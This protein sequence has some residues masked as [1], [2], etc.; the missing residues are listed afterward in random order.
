MKPKK[1]VEIQKCQVSGKVSDKL[2]KQI[3]CKT[4]LSLMCDVTQRQWQIADDQIY[5]WDDQC[6]SQCCVTLPL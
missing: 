4:P 6:T 5:F 1:L 2:G 3:C